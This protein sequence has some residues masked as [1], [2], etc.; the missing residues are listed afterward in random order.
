[1]DP[2]H[3]KRMAGEQARRNRAARMAREADRWTLYRK[4]FPVGSLRCHF[5]VRDSRGVFRI[6]VSKLD[7]DGIL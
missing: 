6:D 3:F 4:F 1:M 7:P 2:D 5:S